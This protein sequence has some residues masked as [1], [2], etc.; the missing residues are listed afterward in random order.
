MKDVI[1]VQNGLPRHID[2]EN[3]KFLLRAGV[4]LP[5]NVEMHGCYGQES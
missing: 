5:S 1:Y 2:Q 3:L 4:Q